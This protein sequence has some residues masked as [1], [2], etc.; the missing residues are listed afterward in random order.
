MKK[1]QDWQIEILKEVTEGLKQNHY[2]VTKNRTKLVAF[3]PENDKDAFVIYK[4]PK[5]FSTR[6]RKFEV[7]ATGLNGL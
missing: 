1:C 7:I 5:N 2:Y 3:Y 4:T 6:F